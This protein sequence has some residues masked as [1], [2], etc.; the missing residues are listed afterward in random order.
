M[1]RFG[2]CGGGENITGGGEGLGSGTVS[3]SDRSPNERRIGR[4]ADVTM[5]VHGWATAGVASETEG[6]CTVGVSVRFGVLGTEDNFFG[7]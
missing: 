2:R 4:V 1:L 7:V 5:G 6:G 3:V